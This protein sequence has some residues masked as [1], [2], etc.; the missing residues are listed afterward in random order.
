[1]A[2]SENMVET[3]Q[4]AAEMGLFCKMHSVAESTAAAAK[5]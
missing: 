2:A 4:S 1:M 3:S 5:M